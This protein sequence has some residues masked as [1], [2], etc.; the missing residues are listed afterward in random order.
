M[1]VLPALRSPLAGDSVSDAMVGVVVSICGPLWVRPESERLA[2]LP[3]PSL[4]VAELR[5]TAVAASADG[6]LPGGHGVAEGERIGAGAA[7][8]GGDAAIVE[9]ERRRAAGDRH[10]FVEI[11]GQVTVLPAL[12]SPL[13]GDSVKRRDG[14]RCGVDLRAALGQT[15]EREIGGIAGA[16]LDGRGVEIDGGGGQRRRCS[17]RRPRCS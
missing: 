5:L 12:R 8:I 4:M 10:G 17:G 11:E 6:V 1:T 7:R 9:R 13:A 14:R 2:A 16:V 15:G 3:A